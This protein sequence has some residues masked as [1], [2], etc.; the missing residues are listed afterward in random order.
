MSR[1]WSLC[2]AG[3]LEQASQQAELCIKQAEDGGWLDSAGRPLRLRALQTLWRINS[4]LADALLDA[5]D[6]NEALTLL[7]KSYSMATDCR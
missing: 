1:L 7:H 2:T 4:R 6:Y 3:H 5:A